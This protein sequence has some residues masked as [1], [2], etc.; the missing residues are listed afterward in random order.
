VFNILTNPDAEGVL[1][2]VPID[3][4]Y[5][6]STGT[7]YTKSDVIAFIV[8]DAPKLSVLLSESAVKTAGSNG[9][10][11]IILVN[12]G[13]VGLKF[14]NIELVESNDYT[15][16]SANEEYIGNLDSDDTDNV[17]FDI[18]AKSGI[19]ALN[20]KFDLTYLDINNNAYS[21]TIT[22]PVPLYSAS[23]L[24]MLGIKAGTNPLLIIAGLV[25][26]ALAG[27]FVYQRFFA[28]KR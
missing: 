14:L 24:S 6:D 19:T 3:I 25:V 28:K 17:D 20:L 22:V 8:G 4:E 26:L 7:S 13:L 11:S 21:E 12:S 18:Y 5:I 10:V 16:L 1:Y 9:K 27:Y 15:I 2:K 23:Q